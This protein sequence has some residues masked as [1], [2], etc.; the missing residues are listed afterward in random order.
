MRVNI[1]RPN[2]YKTIGSC[3]VFGQEGQKNIDNT[4]DATLAAATIRSSENAG[5]QPSLGQ[6]FRQEYRQFH[7]CRHPRLPYHKRGAG[8]NVQTFF[9]GPPESHRT[10]AVARLACISLEPIAPGPS[11]QESSW[12]VGTETSSARSSG[13]N[14]DRPGLWQAHKGST[15]A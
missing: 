5:G 13:G 15:C 9:G 11:R 14:R 12:H 10:H 6:G 1:I 4:A 3:V 7:P 2:L 8:N